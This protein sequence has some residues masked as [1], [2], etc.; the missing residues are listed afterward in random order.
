[1]LLN[2]YKVELNTIPGSRMLVETM[3]LLGT[4][5]EDSRHRER[6][7][8]IVNLFAPLKNRHLGGIRAKLQD[9][10]G[11]VTFCNQRDLELLLGVAKPGNLCPWTSREYPE[12]DSREFFGMC[13]D[14][15]D[16]QD[17]L[18]EREMYLRGLMAASPEYPSVIPYGYELQRRVHLGRSS[19][20]EELY[21][22]LYDCV[23]ETGYGPDARF[24]TLSQRWS[25]VERSELRWEAA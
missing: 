4:G 21:M 22:M 17:D 10:K 13:A 7:W 12:M 2:P 6:Y 5:F 24:E 8:T 14:E 15:E 3:G 1:M 11:F 20:V 23:P 18:Y 25:R 9:Q 19:D 16:L